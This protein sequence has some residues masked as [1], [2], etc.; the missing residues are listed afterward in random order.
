MEQPI[1]YF[2]GLDVHKDTIAIAAAQSQSRDEPKFVGTTRYSVHQVRKALASSGCA[3][4][5]LAIAYEA[6]PCGY[7]LAREL[8]A[9]GYNCEVVA[10]SRVPRRPADRIKTD[11][12]DALLLARLHRSGELTSVTIP[13][14]ADE[15]VRDLIRARED[16]IKARLSAR[17]QLMALLLRLGQPYRDGKGWTQRH[18]R[19]LAE[20]EFD[21]PLHRIVYTEYR[22]AVDS[23]TDRVTRLD[24]AIRNAS[25]TWRF[26]PV[27]KALMSLRSIDFL[28]AMSIVAE[29][30]DMRRFDHP[31]QL[32]SFLGLVPSEYSSGKSQQRG[33]LT[34]TGNARV[35]RLLVEA[36]W[37]YRFTALISRDIRLRQEGVPTEITNIAWKAQVRLCHRYRKLRYRG[38][39]ANKTCAAVARELAGF[40]WD[41]ARRVRPAEPQ[42]PS[43]HQH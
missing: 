23:A 7:G 12:R 33:A 40:I 6:G 28:S 34:R 37:N 13:D 10:P 16:A 21:D 25:E 1:R 43:K 4:S 32:M 15:A 42:P 38:L 27:V 35:R 5:E 31:R 26:K 9:L 18:L 20:R 36:A 39:H 3:P 2:I 22:L 17:Q 41:I 8:S 11:R 14:P 24:A 29:I 19:F 30:G